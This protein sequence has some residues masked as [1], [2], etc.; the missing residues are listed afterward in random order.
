MSVVHTIGFLRRSK[1]P[2]LVAATNLVLEALKGKESGGTLAFIRKEIES[3]R[4]SIKVKTNL[5]GARYLSFGKYKIEFSTIAHKREYKI[6]HNTIRVDDNI[7]IY[8]EDYLPLMELLDEIIQECFLE[9]I[10]SK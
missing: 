8:H 9:Q 6:F 7:N 10:S 4:S 5:V 3:N 2:K 1:D